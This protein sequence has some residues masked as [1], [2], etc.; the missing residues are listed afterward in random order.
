MRGYAKPNLLTPPPPILPRHQHHHLFLCQPR[1][2]QPLKTFSHR[3]LLGLGRM[4]FVSA[5]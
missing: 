5:I 1:P 2:E 3:F 4:A